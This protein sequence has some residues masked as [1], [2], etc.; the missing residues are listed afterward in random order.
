MPDRSAWLRLKLTDG[1]GNR[2]LNRLIQHYHTP[3]K[4]LEA[5]GEWNA[6]GVPERIAT[7]VL[8]A[9]D[10]AVSKAQR[11]LEGHD[12]RIIHRWDKESYPSLLN[13]IDDPPALLFV[14]GS[15]PQTDMFAVVG[16]RRASTGGLALTRLICQ[17]LGR[18]GITTVSG[19]ARGI[20][21]AAH[22]GS[23][24]GDGATVAVLGSG[25]DRIY[26]P[27][28][29]RLAEQ[30]LERGAIITEYPPGAAPLPGHFPGRNR[31]ISG[32]CRGLLVVEAAHGSGSLISVD[33]ALRQGREVFA[34][35]GSVM[36]ETSGGVNRLLKDGAHVVT[37]PGDILDVLWPGC[38]PVS[39]R[40]AENKFVGQL[41]H[42]QS[43]VYKNVDFTPRS[44]DEV[45]RLSAL[46]PME[47]SAILLHLELAGRVA[48]H[49]GGRYARTQLPAGTP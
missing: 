11:I 31:I 4:A 34:V 26:P 8:S 32:L 48:Q 5:K 23:L 49:P 36:C 27:E 40:E 35:P 30:I 1:L 25:I 22:H 9:D 41:D 29:D 6:H 12:T 42:N 20:D 2:R 10:P 39:E 33:F 28:H 15:I 46:T 13:Q 19:L 7:A 17:D 14:R 43:I 16:A 38:P 24:E 21:A 45:V 37:E 18:H 47:V 3:E 44:I